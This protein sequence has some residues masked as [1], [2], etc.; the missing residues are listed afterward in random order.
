MLPL[1]AGQH[2]ADGR[3]VEAA[4]PD[5][6]ILIVV[7]AGRFLMGSSGLET[8]DQGADAGRISN[9]RP[10]HEVTIKAPF[11]LAVHEVTRGAFARFVSAT[12]RDMAGCGQWEQ[13]GWVMYDNLNWANPGFP[14]TETDPAVCVSLKDAEAY[15]AW[16][17]AGTGENYRLPSE[18]EWEYAARAGATGQH[19]WQAEEEACGQANAPDEA[20]ADEDGL[21]RRP[22]IIVAC[23]DWFAC[24]S[25]VGTFAANGFGLHDMLGN[26]WEW[27]A[28]CYADSYDN[29]PDDG[30]ARKDWDCTQRV[31]RGGSWKYP[32]RTARFDIRGPGQLGQHHDSDPS[33]HRS[34]DIC[35]GS[36]HG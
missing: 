9:E 3:A 26:V 24:T 23:N 34:S 1:H 31:L 5:C 10:L 20:A 19:S 36:Q 4:C 2:S 11:E 25:P 16:L 33:N 14:Q 21:P 15:I 18:A 8:V 30:T 13:T 12:G 6:P 7:P 27:V 17:N 35:T 29:A 32:S 28:D 22:G